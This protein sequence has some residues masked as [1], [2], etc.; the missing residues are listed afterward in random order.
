MVVF[1]VPSYSPKYYTFQFFWYPPSREK[2]T[3]S[4]AHLEKKREM[5]VT[6]CMHGFQTLR[7]T[8]K[9]PK[10]AF[11]SV[12]SKTRTRTKHQMQGSGLQGCSLM[13]PVARDSEKEAMPKA[14]IQFFIYYF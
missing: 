12:Y 10:P 11:N 3:T 7:D 6:Q 14:R 8:E 9:K 1:T 4:K 5:P 13:D 2:E